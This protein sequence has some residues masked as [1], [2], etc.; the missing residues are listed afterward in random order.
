[1]NCE[2]NN[3]KTYLIDSLICDF[4]LVLISE[5]LEN[6]PSLS[7]TQ[8]RRELDS[9]EIDL[10]KSINRN[11]ENFFLLEREKYQIYRDLMLKGSFDRGLKE[12]IS[13]F[14]YSCN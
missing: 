5:E 4:G 14:T 8:F 7:W 3:I 13:T 2:L 1:M 12:C 6:W 10:A 9:Q 11:W